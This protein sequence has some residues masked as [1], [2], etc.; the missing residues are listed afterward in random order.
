MT[1]PESR[2]TALRLVVVLGFLAMAL[3]GCGGHSTAPPTKSAQRGMTEDIGGVPEEKAFKEIEVVL[4][5][6][7][8][9]SAL[10]EF[11]PRRN[12]ANHFYIDRDSISIGSDRVIRYSVVIKSP[13]GAINASYEGMRCKT[14]EYKVYAFGT[15]NNE[16]AK[17]PDEQWRYVP[18][19]SPNFRFT[20]YKDYFCDI[21]AIAGNNEKDLIANIVGNPLDSESTRKR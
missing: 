16:W 6:Y 4:P 10:L 1:G 3:G 13:T 12:S 15:G 7:P 11:L 2:R 21:E 9:D 8:Q 20:L 5:A 14:S 19:E 17:V 18:R